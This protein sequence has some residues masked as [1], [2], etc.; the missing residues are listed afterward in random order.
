MLYSFT[1]YLSDSS[2]RD[3]K[4]GVEAGDTG[5]EGLEKVSCPSTIIKNW[6]RNLRNHGAQ[7]P[8]GKEQICPRSHIVIH[9][10]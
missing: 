10:E 2:V 9:G 8:L 7:H 1:H 4:L 6:D 3:K 5:Q